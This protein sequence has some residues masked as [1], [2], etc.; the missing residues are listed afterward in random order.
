MSLKLIESKGK[1][2]LLFVMKTYSTGKGLAPLIFQSGARRR[3]FN[4]WSILVLKQGAYL[5]LSRICVLNYLNV[6]VK[7]QIPNVRHTSKNE[8]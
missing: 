2:V 6:F 3:W 4:V 8:K 1:F 7:R 5:H